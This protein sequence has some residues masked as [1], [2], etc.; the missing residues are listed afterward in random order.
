MNI[1]TKF[2][3][4]MRDWL[5]PDDKKN[6]SSISS[7]IEYCASETWS[8]ITLDFKLGF[9]DEYVN[10]Y[11]SAFDAKE[12]QQ[13]RDAMLL[14]QAHAQSALDDLDSVSEQ[15]LAD[16]KKQQIARDIA[17]KESSGC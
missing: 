14:I 7:S 13:M 5:V 17:E 6:T 16:V 3:S 12:Y 10:V 2:E 4:D 8:E 11:M 9:R 1:E 15:F